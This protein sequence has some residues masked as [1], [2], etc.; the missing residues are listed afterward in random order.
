[1]GSLASCLPRER[2]EGEGSPQAAGRTRTRVRSPARSASR[3]Y[4]L[5]AV[6]PPAL[7]LTAGPEVPR[8][9]GAACGG[10]EGARYVLA[11]P[12]TGT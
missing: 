4:Q 7:V 2:G 5:L 8:P 11:T 12:V 3:L 1:M 10:T 6:R 9:P